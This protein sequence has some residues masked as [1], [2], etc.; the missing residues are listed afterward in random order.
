MASPLANLGIGMAG[1]DGCELGDDVFDRR[2]RGRAR[3]S[4][5]ATEAAVPWYQ[6][7]DGRTRCAPVGILVTQAKQ[8]CGCCRLAYAGKAPT[9][10]I[11]R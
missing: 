10:F 3:R 1:L 9:I 6:D 11:D 5:A 8:S 2:A 7:A 4:A